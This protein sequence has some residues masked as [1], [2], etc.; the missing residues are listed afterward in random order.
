MMRTET[1]EFEDGSS[2]TAEALIT[3]ADSPIAMFVLAHGAGAGMR[4]KFMEDAAQ[5]FARHGIS[6]FRYEFPYMRAGRSRTDAPAVAEATVRRAVEAA[7]R[8][9]AVPIIAGGKSFGGRMTSHAAASGSIPQARMLV[10]LG[11]PLHPPNKPS[12]TR[13]DHLDRVQQP[14]LFHQGTRDTLADITLIRE[15]TDRLGERAQ[16]HVIETADHSFHVLKKQTGM[17]DADV[18]EVVA[19]RTVIALLRCGLSSHVPSS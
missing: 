16:L 2:G 10:F 17:S 9:T 19:E 3:N 14:M 11:F 18:L 12:T 13:A 7:A 1:I 8:I 4:H 5:A 6:V 15:V